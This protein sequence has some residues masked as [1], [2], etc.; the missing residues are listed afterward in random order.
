MICSVSYNDN[1][2]KCFNENTILNQNKNVLNFILK[3]FL[4]TEV[5]F[6]FNGNK[7]F[8]IKS[9]KIFLIKCQFFRYLYEYTKCDKLFKFNLEYEINEETLTLFF[10]LLH[11]D[12][13]KNIDKGLIYPYI[14][15]LHFISDILC[16]EDIKQY[17]ENIIAESLNEHNF[18]IF[19]EFCLDKNNDNYNIITGRNRLFRYLIIWL[20][21]FNDN[22]TKSYPLNKLI[23]QFHET[24]IGFNDYDIIKHELI[25][26]T[27]NINL[28]VWTNFCNNCN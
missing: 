26:S 18:G 3:H 22:N 10:M 24:I 15:E 2:C 17:C 9:N 1:W 25:Y 21:F 13:F 5:Q 27:T 20:K 12:D 28:T 14:T 4:D 16:N 7:I 6:I 23:E 8:T 19:L 11:S